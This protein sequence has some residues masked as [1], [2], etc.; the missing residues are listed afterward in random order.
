MR[1]I[2]TMSHE[3]AHEYLIGQGRISGEEEDHE[4]LTDLLAVFLGFGVMLA[5]SSLR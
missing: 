3:L 2:A 1:L 4:Q 5:N